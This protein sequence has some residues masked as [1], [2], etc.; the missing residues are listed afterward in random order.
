MIVDIVQCHSSR[1]ISLATT[2]PGGNKDILD[3]DS[4]DNPPPIRLVRLRK[5]QFY[6]NRAG[7]SY[8]RGMQEPDYDKCQYAMDA[9]V[10]SAMRNEVI[11]N[12]HR[13]TLFLLPKWVPRP[14]SRGMPRV[15][16]MTT[17]LI[18]LVPILNR[19]DVPLRIGNRPRATDRRSRISP[20]LTTAL[21]AARTQ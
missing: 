13:I 18:E 12:H 4:K 19:L 5:I 7:S 21:D 6:I 2:I 11:V 16:T 17:A 8:E 9:N 15:P 10:M 14:R 3:H 1:N 20:R